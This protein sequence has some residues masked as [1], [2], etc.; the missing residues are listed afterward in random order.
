MKWWWVRIE[1]KLDL[2]LAAL[3][4]TK[5]QEG[6]M[7]KTLDDVLADVIAQKTVVGSAVTLLQ[8]IKAA[9]DAA[10]AAGDMSKVEAIA[11]GIEANTA[12]LAAGVSANT[13]T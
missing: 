10:I 12:D 5:T 11:D 13:I 7:A 9:L 6:I 4:A 2:I 8:G 3:R 1:G